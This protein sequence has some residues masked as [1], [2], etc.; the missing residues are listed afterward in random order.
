MNLL[1]D[2]VTVKL[3]EA[4]AKILEFS[5]CYG[6]YVYVTVWRGTEKGEKLVHIDHEGKKIWERHYTDSVDEFGMFRE[7]E[8]VV[9]NPTTSNIEVINL[10]DHSIVEVPHQYSFPDTSTM[11]IY[12]FS[13]TKYLAIIEQ[14]S[15]ENKL[16]VS[17]YHVDAQVKKITD[18][19]I[20][21]EIIGST[22]SKF[23]N[24]SKVGWFLTKQEQ[25]L[26]FHV[27]DLKTN[28]EEGTHKTYTINNTIGATVGMENLSLA[29]I[30]MW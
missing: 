8:V 13:E 21:E 16:V 20:E 19:K 2:T 1:K 23:D 9:N 15:S 7:N 30:N 14:G 5:S 28:Q 3:Q 4:P 29:L 11:H 22:I 10:V 25:M 18:W 27:F 17:Y 26:K 12:T 24:H 6:G